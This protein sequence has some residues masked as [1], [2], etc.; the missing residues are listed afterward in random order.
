MENL[1]IATF[2]C[3][4]RRVLEDGKIPMEYVISHLKRRENEF[5][6]LV[7]LGDNYYGKKQKVK[8]DGVEVKKINHIQEDLEYGFEL[9]ENLNI[10]SKYLIM[11]NHDVEDT[12]GKA[13]IG[14]QSQVAKTDKF[15]VMFPFKSEIITLTTG[16]RFK[17]IFIDTTV[18]SI[19]AN[20][21]CYDF[22]LNK[23]SLN[24]I[25]EQ[26]A[27]IIRELNDD[28][29]DYFIFFAHEPLYSVKTK[30]FVEDN[31]SHLIDDVLDGL[32]KL[33]LSNSVGKNIYYVC[34][35]NHM[36]QSGIVSD[37]SGNSIKQI[38]CG[39]GGGEK[40]NFDLDNKIFNKNDFTYCIDS[41]KQPYGYLEIFLNNNGIQYSYVN[42]QSDGKTNIYN[43]K[44]LIQYK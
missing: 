29:I 35:D 8:I 2:G 6:H 16:T 34:A 14:L 39:T 22:V 41:T 32:G 18:Y 15:N 19:K 43:K 23:N 10:Q 27:F 13:C 42:V 36:Y 38:V 5:A 4:N 20:P 1:R 24:I 12:L 40:D 11:G 37:K 9:V 26:N 25:E 17:Y 28:S 33:I 44:Y 31:K 7:I 21:S 30:I 3:W